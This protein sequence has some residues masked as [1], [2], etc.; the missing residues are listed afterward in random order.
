MQKDANGKN[1]KIRKCE[2]V[3]V[4]E[5][6]EN[7]TIPKKAHD[8]KIENVCN[9]ENQGKLRIGQFQK[10]QIAEKYEN[11]KI[12]DSESVKNLKIRKCKKLQNQGK[13]RIGN[14]KLPRPPDP[15]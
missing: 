12:K 15:L 7:R 11:M 14:R 4:V 8:K 9:W 6:F 3:Q 13:L 10:K 5:K 1:L 2:N